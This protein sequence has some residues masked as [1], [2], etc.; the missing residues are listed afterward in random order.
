MRRSPQKWARKAA[1]AALVCVALALQARAATWFVIV[2]G[3]GGEPDYEQRFTAAANELDRIF[4]AEGPA[5]HVTMLTGANATAAQLHDALAAV[6]RQAKPE[7]DFALILIGHGSF[8][9]V[10]YKFNLVGPDMTAAQ[11]AELCDKISA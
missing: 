9:G 11:L 2:S 7:D 4:Q 5:V 8:D 1:I 10:E 3:I 6:A